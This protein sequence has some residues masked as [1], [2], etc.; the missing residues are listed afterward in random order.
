MYLRKKAQET[1][2]E[3]ISKKVQDEHE[4]SHI[5][6]IDSAN[7]DDLDIHSSIAERT[8]LGS[9]STLVQDNGTD[10]DDT[11]SFHTVDSATSILEDMDILSF[12]SF[13][14]GISG[15]LVIFSDGLRFMRTS[16]LSS[17]RKEEWSRPWSQL[18]EISKA[19]HNVAKLVKTEGL[20]L[21]FSGGI[22]F[23]LE[24]VNQ[25]DKAFNCIL[26][27]SG[28]R[29]QIVQPGARLHET[30]DEDGGVVTYDQ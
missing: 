23:E 17:T 29:F 15:R 16:P 10:G 6:R 21:V 9:G 24:Q 20:D 26:G 11:A 5:H 25:R 30:F 2:A 3:L 1:R 28:L 8:A 4:S 12:R 13:M 14:Q 27:F 22:K 18:V 7:A 19:D